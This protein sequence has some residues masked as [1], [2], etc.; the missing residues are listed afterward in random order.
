MKEVY[1]ETASKVRAESGGKVFWMARGMRQEC[2]FIVIVAKLFA[3]LLTDLN[4]RMEK[5][6]RERWR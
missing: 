4:E 2:P 3:L 6:G 1:E 5:R